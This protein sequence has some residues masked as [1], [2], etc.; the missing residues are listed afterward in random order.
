MV[1]MGMPAGTP[2]TLSCIL[3]PCLIVYFLPRTSA[4]GAILLTG[5]MGGA[6]VAHWRVG[7]AF[8]HCIAVI[9]LLWTGLCLRDTAIWQSVNP[10]RTR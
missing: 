2:F 6:I 3:L 9:L 5:Y 4:I 10:F 7:E 8:A 1:A